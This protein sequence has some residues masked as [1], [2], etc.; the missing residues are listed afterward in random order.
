MDTQQ[1]TLDREM[2]EAQKFL[3][4]APQFDEPFALTRQEKARLVSNKRDKLYHIALRTVLAF[5]VCVIALM[6][7]FKF[8]EDFLD[9]NSRIGLL[10]ESISRQEEKLSCPKI[11]V[12]AEFQDA[13]ESSLVLPL[14][15]P[16]NKEDVSIR[17]EFTH[18]KFVITLANYAENIQD[19][20]E[21]LSDSSIMDAV[22][23]YKQ[24]TD[25]IVEVYCRDV[26]ECNID[27]NDSLLTVTFG[28]LSEQYRAK[29]VVWLPY[30]DRNRF[31]LPEWR[32]E[33]DKFAKDNGLKLYMASDMLEEYTQEDVIAFANEIKADMVIGIQIET[34]SEQQSHIKGVCNTSYFI[35]D[36]NSVVLTVRMAEIVMDVTQISL[37]GFEEA[38]ENYLLVQKAVVPSALIKIIVNQKEIESVEANYKFNEKLIVALQK[39]ISNVLETYKN[40]VEVIN[41]S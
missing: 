13:P 20:I 14:A 32:Q 10:M 3:E 21:L 12:K 23:I 22:G 25:V 2:Q 28:S 36:F 11:N 35:P 19:E 18:N 41:E 39:T 29:V 7:G 38:N 5:M 17:N 4:Q 37:T 1:K 26:Y 33:F 30:E 9:A 40:E 16:I 15:V 8:C 34:T 24:D 31:A 27:V 6:V